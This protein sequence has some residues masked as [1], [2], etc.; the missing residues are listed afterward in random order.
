MKRHKF[1]IIIILML[2][3]LPGAVM[4]GSG[5][6]YSSDRLSSSTVNC[7]RQ[8]AHGFIWVSTEYGLNRFDGYRF[9][10]YFHNASDTTSLITNEATAIFN[11]S[12]GRLWVG[13]DKGLMRFDYELNCFRRYKFPGGTRP[14]V[15][16]I[17]E[18]RDGTLL[19]ATSGYGLY[20]IRAGEEKIYRDPTLRHAAA[21]DYVTHLFEDSHGGMWQCSH[22]ARATRITKTSSGR[23]RFTDYNL[24]AG[25]AVSILSA[26]SKGTLIVCMYGILIY[27]YSTGA[28]HDAGY[29]LKLLNGETSIRCA[30]KDRNGGLLIGTSGN[31]LMVI[32]AGQR[33]LKKVEVSVTGFDLSTANVN[34][35]YEDKDANI[36]ISCNKKGL[37]RLSNGG[38]AFTSATFAEQHCY[39]GSSISSMAAGPDGGFYVTVQKAGV[40]Y[41]DSSGHI[42][43]HPSSPPAPNTIYKDSHGGYWLC[44]ENK[45]YSYLPQSGEAHLVSQYTG[46]G[47]NCMT[48]DGHGT[49]YICNYGTGLIIFNKSTG[50]SETISMR[51]KTRPA[52]SLVNDWIKALHVDKHGRLWI[53]TVDGVSCMDT[54]TQSFNTI[55]GGT[56]LK[57]VPSLSISETRQGQILIG[58]NAGLFAYDLSKN[59]LFRPTGT[60]KLRNTSIY[61]I[62]EDRRGGLWMSTAAGIWQY[63]R[64]HKRLIGH[65]R[66]N[67]LVD[68]EYIIGAAFHAADDRITFATNDGITSFYPKDVRSN[69]TKMDSVYL[70]GIIVDGHPRNCLND[71]FT[72]AHDEN[73]ITLEYSLLSY[74]HA[75]EI[76]FQYKINDA[77]RWLSLAEG[78]NTISLNKL[79]PGTYK[80]QVRAAS[81]GTASEH[82]KVITITVKS[83]WY[84]S[85]PAFLVYALLVAAV[86]TLFIRLYE[87]RRKE[88]LDEAKMRFLINATHDIRSPLTLIVDPLK[89]LRQSVH[90]AE[91]KSYIDTI[92]RNAQKLLLLVNSILDQ[93][94]IDKNQMHLHC[95][96]TNL[97]EYLSASCAMF[98]YNADQHCIALRIDCSENM[99][100]AWIDRVNFDKVMQNLLSNAFKFTPDG[101]E[102]IV[103]TS[104]KD[105]KFIVEVIDTGCGFADNDTEKLFDRFYQ[106]IAKSGRQQSGTGIGLNLSRTIV[107]MHGGTITAFN[108]TDNVQGAVIHIELPVGNTHLKP[109]EIMTGEEETES[110]PAM[111]HRQASKN[112]HVLVVDDDAE[113]AEYIRRELADWYR[114]DVCANGQQAM[115]TLLKGG[116][117]LVVSDV[118]MPVMDGITLLK[119][120]KA[121]S[122]VSDVPV[123]LLTSKSDVA[124]RLEGI[125]K[126]ADAYIA[127]P[128]DMNEL[129]VVADN[130]ISNVRRLRG[131]FSGAQR[132]S[133]KV[134]NIEVKGNNDTL[135]ER[136]MKVL[137]DNIS[138]PD[139]NV[140]KLSVDVGISRAQ[141]HRKMKEI[142]GIS[143]GEFIRN[144]KLEQAARLI[145]KG[146][147]NI[148]QV[149]YAVGFNN[150]TH[151]STVFKKHF[152]MSPSE[153][154]EKHSA[155]KK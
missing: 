84:A 141:L 135:M 75:D 100:Q 37:Y 64:R 150:S 19:I 118:M 126:G 21:D 98:R 3:S 101:G 146:D 31:G 74:R 45:L 15:M 16:N 30:A 46:W 8:D 20:C 86:I 81:N 33:T 63:D 27:D 1:I 139:F 68:K 109:E 102:I 47:L 147:I 82:V 40:Y 144:L 23:R 130:L 38:N 34:D 154:A 113:I 17:T 11:D 62:V 25:P 56:L 91:G 108:R 89:R 106:G 80:I 43:G 10:S 119:K 131:K 124:D 112:C 97:P 79:K 152:G 67:G 42:T 51:D 50:R 95:Q 151:F 36:W 145:E 9:T 142:T 69:H 153:Y 137:N 48:D 110:K 18:L 32:P 105:D 70:T 29:D 55:P 117:D 13:C 92:D 123:I 125:R 138:D 85:T 14:R 115:D 132:Q 44:S 5:Q 49:Y 78:T 120:I 93:R 57:G 60:Q 121:N 149:A 39:L 7:V 155:G 76:S 122:L 41:L 128:F 107:K 148:T 24:S 58:T 6:F 4:A 127:K 116:Y 22:L 26:G 111:Q 61:S 140:E 143:T 94:R 12:H 129:R 71:E 136:I 54:K 35:V 133:D 83:P 72:V 66:G 65:I 52:G 104:C 96:P 73:T 134:E 88:E 90:D 2:A 59:K 28:I 87:R 114:V 103:H 53:G 77:G 99:P